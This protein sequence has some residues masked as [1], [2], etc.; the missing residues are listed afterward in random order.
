[1]SMKGT[2]RA[3][4]STAMLLA[5][6]AVPADAGAGGFC[7]GGKLTEGN[8]NTVTMGKN[9]FS[10]T[11][12]RVEPGTEVTWVNKDP[13]PHTVTGAAGAWGSGHKEIASGTR[14]AFRF[15]DPGVYTYTCLLH[16]GMAGTVVVGD[17]IGRGAAVESIDVE[18]VSASAD[19]PASSAVRPVEQA[20]STGAW[21]GIAIAAAALGGGAGYGL[22]RRRRE[23]DTVA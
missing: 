10:P 22:G 15:D 21:A 5:L 1:M 9:C 4:L 17:G 14:A 16:P 20:S 6:L 8:G 18:P 7:Q 2:V 23:A 12:L 3:V 11:V 19:R 13:A